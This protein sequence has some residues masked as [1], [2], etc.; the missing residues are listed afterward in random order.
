MK[1]GRFKLKESH[2]LVIWSVLTLAAIYLLIRFAALSFSD[3]SGQ[4][5]ISVK[6]AFMSGLYVK[7][8]ESGSSLLQ[9]SAEG[10]QEAG[11]FPMNLVGNVFALDNFLKNDSSKFVMAQEPS[12]LISQGILKQ[13]DSSGNHLLEENSAVNSMGGIGFYDVTNGHLSREYI[14]TNGAIYNSSTINEANSGNG[15]LTVGYVD[16]NVF[17]ETEDS[18]LGTPVAEEVMKTNNG[19]QFTLDQL[20]DVAFLVRNFYI[21]DPSTKVTDSL[22][23]SDKML[24]EDMRIKQGNDKPQILIYHTH[25]QEAYI[26]SKEGVVEDTVVGV[27]SYLTKILENDYGYNVIHDK[28]H[29]DIVTGKLDRSL[30]YD[31]ALDGIEKILKDNPSI[32]VVIDLHRDANSART[33]TINGQE[34]AQ[35]MLFNGLSRDQKGPLTNLDNPYLQDNLAFSLQLQLKALNM[36]PGLFLK[37]YLKFLRYNL[38]VRPK[39]LLVELGTD[40]NTLQSAMNAMP[41]FAEV[42]DAVL[43]GK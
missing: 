32:E 41:P 25:S 28:T 15:Q 1:K 17:P 39:S 23:N 12:S 16:G 40:Y 10:K 36:H 9:Y 26:D 43:K 18:N 29:Y 27:G 11:S 5:D 34:T 22:F 13:S 19:T 14:L 30:A 37:D 3:E 33:T 31:Y 38:H 42:L 6:D 8:M 20:K 24:S 7:A 35:I 21:V 4:A 2:Y